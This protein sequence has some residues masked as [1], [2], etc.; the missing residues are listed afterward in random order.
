MG[1]FTPIIVTT[2]R[3]ISRMAPYDAHY[4]WG[5]TSSDVMIYDSAMTTINKYHGGPYQEALSAVTTN[6][7]SAY[8]LNGGEFA[9]YGVEYKTGTNGYITWINNGKPA[10]TVRPSAIGACRGLMTYHMLI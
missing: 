2:L 7:Q 5:N 9:I 6:K 10:W 8:Q 3:E 1:R 4:Y